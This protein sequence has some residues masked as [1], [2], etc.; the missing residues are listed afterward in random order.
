[1]STLIHDG[2][3]A[4]GIG[5]LLYMATIAVTAVAAVFAPAPQRRR[6]ARA[7]L[8]ILLRRRDVEEPQR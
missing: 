4:A 2:A 7:V 1:M 8:T 5:T 6:D 3:L